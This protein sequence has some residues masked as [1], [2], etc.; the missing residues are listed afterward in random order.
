[1]ERIVIITFKPLKGH[2]KSLEKLVLDHWNRLNALGLVS[3]RRPVI[4][5]AADGSL[6]EVFGWKSAGAIEAAHSNPEVQRLWAEFAEVCEYVPLGK[7][8]ESENLFP[9]FEAVH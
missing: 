8:E 4:A 6:V 3:K 2:E 1:M 7:L 5:R 9:E